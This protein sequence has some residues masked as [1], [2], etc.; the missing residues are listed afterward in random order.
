MPI[1]VPYDILFCERILIL[2]ADLVSGINEAT[3]S[4]IKKVFTLDMAKQ[5]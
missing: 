1:N 2:M 3:E 4:L 5:L